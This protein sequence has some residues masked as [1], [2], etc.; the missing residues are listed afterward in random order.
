MVA[1]VRGPWKALGLAVLC[2]C[3]G[4]DNSTVE[5]SSRSASSAECP[6]GGTVVVVGGASVATVCNGADGRDGEPGLPGER[7]T[8]GV[9]GS[10]GV[11]GATGPAGSTS[12]L[13]SE[14]VGRIAAN[15]SLHCDCRVHRGPL[16]GH[17][18][19]TKTSTGTM[20]PLTVGRGHERVP[21]YSDHR[22]RCSARSLHGPALDVATR[23]S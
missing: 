1:R 9:D 3:G 5:V 19:G 7:G 16:V 11:D 15:E 12:Q 13:T 21:R 22:S 17:G 10:N 8:D 4:D 20:T 14:I 6:T 23:W 2:G 18:T